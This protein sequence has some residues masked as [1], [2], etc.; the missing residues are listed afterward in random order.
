MM[1]SQ[2]E[3]LICGHAYMVSENTAEARGITEAS[4]LNPQKA[5][6]SFYPTWHKEREKLYTSIPDIILDNP[7]TESL[8]LDFK[9]FKY[10]SSNHTSVTVGLFLFSLENA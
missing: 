9:W 5:A 1:V 4:H 3:A 8:C 6:A 7:K 10:F 2:S